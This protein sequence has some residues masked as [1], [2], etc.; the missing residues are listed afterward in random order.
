MKQHYHEN[1]NTNN[2]KWCND[3]KKCVIT[4]WCKDNAGS[5]NYDTRSNEKLKPTNQNE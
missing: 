3:N 5:C 1:K 4:W 2:P